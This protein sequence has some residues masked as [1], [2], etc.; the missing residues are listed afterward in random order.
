MKEEI[1]YFPAEH[2]ATYLYKYLMGG[3]KADFPDLFLG[4]FVSYHKNSDVKSMQSQSFI[5]ELYLRDPGHQRNSIFNI[6]EGDNS[7][8]FNK[9]DILVI[10]SLIENLYQNVFMEF[11]RQ[12]NNEKHSGTEGLV[13]LNL[14]KFFTYN[15]HNTLSYQMVTL[16]GF[17]FL[18]EF[19]ITTNDKYTSN[20]SVNR[21]SCPIRTQK[22]PIQ[23]TL[24]DYKDNLLKKPIPINNNLFGGKSD[25]S[26]YFIPDEFGMTE[27]VVENLF[28]SFSK[29]ISGSQ[30]GDL[31]ETI[32]HNFFSG[33]DA[34]L[35]PINLAFFLDKDKIENSEKKLE[36]IITDERTLQIIH[37]QNKK[38][39]IDTIGHLINMSPG[40]VSNKLREARKL[41]VAIGLNPDVYIYPKYNIN[42]K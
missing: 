17:K 9:G 4:F 12:F 23:E 15:L 13:F 20:F 18:A 39:S 37:L 22:G 32:F 6:V 19:S 2:A 26:C 38:E 30:K 41:I 29:W 3:F 14:M 36:D 8:Q 40:Y 28:S 35:N 5:F 25:E 21:I 27:T 10:D 11:E 31:G 1:I 33:M 7:Y 16:A 34:D 42:K 24:L